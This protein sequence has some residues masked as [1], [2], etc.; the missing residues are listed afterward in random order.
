[1]ITELTF[2]SIWIAL[3][4]GIISFFSPCIFPLVPAYLAQLTGSQVAENKL[5][6]NKVTILS[7]SFGFMIGFT[8]VF[9]L[10]GASSTFIGQIFWENR[11][12]LEKLGGI[13]IVLLGMQMS[14]VISFQF[15]LS[16]KRMKVTRTKHTTSFFRSIIFG[17]IFAIGWSP[18]IGLALSS[19]LI[20]AAQSSTMMAGMFLLLIY[21]I[22]L[23]VPFILVA[24]LYSSSLNKLR[25]FNRFLPM[26][27][28]LSGVVLIVL[29]VML[30]TGLFNILSSYLARFIPFNF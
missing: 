18:C 15:L 7:R 8:L 16:E 17:L 13:I 30:Y 11:K 10:I 19:I 1:M 14:G 20:L 3:F 22:G 25:K 27:Q 24:L 21:S 6:V 29:G 12:L 9:L 23:G 28:Q 4:A 5:N 26:I 2:A